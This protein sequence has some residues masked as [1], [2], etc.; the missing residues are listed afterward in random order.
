LSL[1]R[2]GK[3]LSAGGNAALSV[4]GCLAAVWLGH[5]AATALNPAK[6]S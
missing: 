4:F 6:P 3:L 1:V 5:L 2:D